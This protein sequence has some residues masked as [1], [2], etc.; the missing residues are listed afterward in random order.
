MSNAETKP[1]KPGQKTS[2]DIWCWTLLEK[3]KEN[4]ALNDKENWIVINAALLALGDLERTD[5]ALYLNM[6]Q[7]IKRG[8]RPA[9][10]IIHGDSMETYGAPGNHV[11]Q[12]RRK[13]R[14]N[15]L[16]EDV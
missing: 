13:N 12:R 10:G 4:H 2:A 16:R 14:R 8:H 11:K 5:R 3:L 1:K 7:D 9:P 15:T 6:V